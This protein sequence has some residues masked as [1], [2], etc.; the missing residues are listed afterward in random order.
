MTVWICEIFF[1]FSLVMIFY[2]YVG[3]PVCISLLSR[4]RRRQ[5]D[6][7]A[8]L[9]SVSILIA[10]YNEEKNI[11]QTIINKMH[12][13]YPENKLQ[14]IVVSDESTDKTDEIVKGFK[15]KNVKLFRQNP[16]AGKTSALNMAVPHATGEI[17]VFSDANSIYAKN[18]LKHITANFHDP[19]VGYVTG[20]MIY[21]NPDGTAIGDGCSAYMK[22]E[23]ILRTLETR[24]GSVVGV[25]GGIDA[26]RKSIYSTLNPDQL[27]DF[28]QPLKVIERGYRV[29]YEPEAILEEPALSVSDD[30]Y[31]MRVR[32]TLRALNALRDLSQ[33]L[34]G[35]SGLLFAWQLWSHKV[36]RYLSF[37]FLLM[38]YVSNLLLWRESIFYRLTFTLQT[39]CYFL[40]VLS[41]I[42]ERMN[43]KISLIY[44]FHY[45]VI[46]NVAASHAFLKFIAGEKQAVWTPRKG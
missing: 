33:L 20:K 22:Y 45:F 35:S 28:V 12:L 38:A 37:V 14:I 8:Y 34:W 3:Y 1:F 40:S 29:V 36:F 18:A 44:Y 9:P 24:I 17:L 27:P 32:V 25:D 11:E 30:E 23:N 19:N 26:M 2:V 39:A 7:A 10:A 4:L 21:T 41:L 13:D 16:R 46:L 31:R 43:C 6:K 42:L 15:D 5:I